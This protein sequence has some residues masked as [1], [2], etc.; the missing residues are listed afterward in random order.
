MN[1]YTTCLC[2]D[3]ALSAVGS[4]SSR[5]S[6]VGSKQSGVRSGI[7]VAFRESIESHLDALRADWRKAS[8]TGRQTMHDEVL[9]RECRVFDTVTAAVEPYMPFSAPFALRPSKGRGEA[10]GKR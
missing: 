7:V 9:A 6:E 5:S 10:R 4:T 3:S 1:S 8:D 2:I